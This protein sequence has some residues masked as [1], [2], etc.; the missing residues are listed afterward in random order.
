MQP[1]INNEAP[2]KVIQ[3]LMGH[4]KSEITRI[5]A[6]LSGQLRE[7]Y[8]RSIF[9]RTAGEIA[10]LYFLSKQYCKNKCSPLAYFLY[11]A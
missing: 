3:N 6:Y 9:E 7:N 11:L 2:L 4:E 5:Y 10:V 1:L 8:I